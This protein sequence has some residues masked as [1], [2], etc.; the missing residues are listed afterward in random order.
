L[1]DQPDPRVLPAWASCGPSPG[2]RWLTAE[3]PFLGCWL[4]WSGPGSGLSVSDKSARGSAGAS[5]HASPFPF[6]STTTTTNNRRHGVGRYL[7]TLHRRLHC[8]FS[9]PATGQHRAPL[10]SPESITP[11]PEDGKRKHKMMVV[12]PHAISFLLLPAL[13]D[14]RVAAD[15]SY[16]TPT[17]PRSH[18]RKKDVRDVGG[19]VQSGHCTSGTPAVCTVH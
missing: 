15:S 10:D 12:C 19:P 16:L 17:R 9:R 5:G 2:P 18:V 13:P 8:G 1:Q 3:G 7:G 11:P 4:V 14:S 6:L